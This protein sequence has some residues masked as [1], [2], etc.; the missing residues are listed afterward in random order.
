MY[1]SVQ[2]LFFSLMCLPW[3]RGKSITVYNPASLIVARLVEATRGKEGLHQRALLF[4]EACS[5][6]DTDCVLLRTGG[7]GHLTNQA[8]VPGRRSVPVLASHER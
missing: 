7:G 2:G 3:L 1:L 4:D 5:M 6:H 8:S